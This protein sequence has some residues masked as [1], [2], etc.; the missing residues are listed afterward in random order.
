MKPTRVRLRFDRFSA[1]AIAVFLVVLA[2]VAHGWCLQAGSVL[3]DHWHQKG[4]RENGWSLDELIRST[5]IAP[6]EWQH[7]W[8]QNQPM[9]WEYARPVFIWVMKVLY[10]VVGVDDPWWLHA[11]SLILHAWAACLVA[12]L[13]WLLTRSWTASC[14]AGAVFTLY[15][16]A[17]ISVAWPSAMNCV[18]HTLLMLGVVLV[19]AHA[20][21]LDLRVSGPA[22]THARGAAPPPALCP[23]A[24]STA[25]LL[26]VAALLT[27][28]NSLLLPIVLVLL[29]VRFGGVAH[30][31]ARWRA[32][33]IFAILGGLFAAWRTVRLQAALPEVYARFLAGDAVEYALWLS[34]KLLHYWVSA[35]WVAPMA[36]GPSGRFN[37]WAEAPGDC[38]LMLGLT[39]ALG[40]VYL[41]VSRGQRGRW[42]W[43]L[44]ILLMLLP[45][46]P[47][48]AT[49]HSGYACAVGVAMMVTVPL[50]GIRRN[51][52]RFVAGGWLALSAI[53]S[54]LGNWQWNA[55][56][57]AERYFNESVRL[58]PPPAG[59]TDVFAI[60]MPFV[61]IYAKPALDHLLPGRFPQL[62]WHTLTFAPQ[63]VVITDPVYVQV[64]DRYTLEV[65]AG[66]QPF[67]SRLVG[68]FLLE[69]FHDGPRIESGTRVHTP[70]FEV[71]VLEADVHG[72]RR[73]RFAFPRP[74]SDPAYCF[75]VATADCGAARLRF[76]GLDPPAQDA[77]I[78]PTTEPPDAAA[79]RRAGE[80]VW[81][82]ADPNALEVLLAGVRSNDAAIAAES[83]AQ[84]DAVA[85]VVARALAAPIQ[86]H[87]AKPHFNAEDL[88]A[89]A[90]WWRNHVDSEILRD[91]R[92]LHEDLAYLVKQRE[93][94]PHSLDWARRVIRTD[95][96]LTGSPFP[97]SREELH[98]K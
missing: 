74:L 19:Y 59:V 49:P 9:Y 31:R 34:A 72:V 58:S 87:F 40:G 43:P 93:E 18:L 4:L 67:F 21:R 80:R 16:H 79:A 84:I 46:L 51:P 20:S 68:R 86:D 83:L 63:P 64:I 15:P 37:P 45:V 7:L 76:Q 89:V 41:Y 22:A 3:D 44:W 70:A 47:V 23:R 29:D 90:R 57:A 92:R 48:I 96:Y 69:A 97:T 12:R 56:I 61:N 33:L 95:L 28:E 85:G 77:A 62:Q 36:V 75:Y 5:R 17:V 54:L 30:A 82:D 53:F 42:L 10:H 39:L 78:E 50:V 25:L 91:I 71:R 35:V 55:V 81:D 98:S 14:L 52:A 6:G 8:W 27:R 73:L 60:N 13:A 24:F 26:W 65:R 1:S 38:L 32:Y 66:D 11:G 2:W 94:L 88:S